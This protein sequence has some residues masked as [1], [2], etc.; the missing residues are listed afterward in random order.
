MVQERLA[1]LA[2]A[3]TGLPA[4]QILRRPWAVPVIEAREATETLDVSP[5]VNCSRAGLAVHVEHCKCGAGVAAIH[6]SHAGAA[7]DD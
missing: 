2:K 1:E 4:R 5:A 7:I 6:P 3:A